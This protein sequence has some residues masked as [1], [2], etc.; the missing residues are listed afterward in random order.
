M[1]SYALL[2][3]RSKPILAL[4]LRRRSVSSSLGPAL[5]TSGLKPNPPPSVL[6]HPVRRLSSSLAQDQNLRFG[7][8][9]IIRLQLRL[10]PLFLRICP[11]RYAPRRICMA[12]F[13]IVRLCRGSRRPIVAS[14]AVFVVTRPSKVSGFGRRPNGPAHP[15]GRGLFFSP[16]RRNCPALFS[17]PPHMR[18]RGH[19]FH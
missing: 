7:F 18:R 15:L 13:P 8:G 12:A 16:T 11:H 10:E 4:S 3:K 19:C 6:V 5:P 1:T 17:A 2:T 9:P 14:T